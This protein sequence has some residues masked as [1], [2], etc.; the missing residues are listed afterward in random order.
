[1]LLEKLSDAPELP[2]LAR[3]P[4]CVRKASRDQ[5][6][7]CQKKDEKYQIDNYIFAHTHFQKVPV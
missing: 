5:H 7:D 1:L 3:V 4:I 6:E 2:A